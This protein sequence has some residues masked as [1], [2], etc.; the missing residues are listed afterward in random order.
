MK[1]NWLSLAAGVSLPFMIVMVFAGIVTGS[2]D[3]TLSDEVKAFTWCKGDSWNYTYAY[4]YEDVHQDG[5]YTFWIEEKDGTT[6]I[7]KFSGNGNITW[8]PQGRGRWV[9]TGER[10]LY[11]PALAIVSSRASM[12][13]EFT[14][15]EY[16][17][18]ESFI[19]TNYTPFYDTYSFPVLKNESWVSMITVDEYYYILMDGKYYDRY[20]NIVS[21]PQRGSRYHEFVHRYLNTSSVNISGRVITTSILSLENGTRVVHVSDEVEN[22]VRIEKYDENGRR[23]SIM[24]LTGW[25]NSS[26]TN[27]RVQVTVEGWTGRPISNATV[28]L[29]GGCQGRTN[30]DGLFECRIPEGTYTLEVSKPGFETWVSRVDIRGDTSLHVSLDARGRIPSLYATLSGGLILT[31]IALITP[32]LDRK[33]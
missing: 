17:H 24:S 25:H 21:G 11:T 31:I 28:T 19:I 8:T 10:I 32:L 14:E 23:I 15:P 2:T 7:M 12:K 22:D 3:T 6:T 1:K 30:P 33:P 20:G 27:P 9:E 18:E 13:I 29:I 4:D 16:H 5:V 26:C